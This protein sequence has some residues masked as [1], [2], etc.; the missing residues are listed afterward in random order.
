[1]FLN[2]YVKDRAFRCLAVNVSSNGLCLSSLSLPAF[3]PT[4]VVGLEFELPGTSETV[5]ARGEVRH[6]ASDPYFRG[7]GVEITG[8]AKVH[9]R[10]IRDYVMEQRA[11]QLRKLLAVIRRNRMH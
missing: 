4:R 10:L 1:M 8:I 9:Q 5:W 6:D 11:R 3:S 7:T 2:E